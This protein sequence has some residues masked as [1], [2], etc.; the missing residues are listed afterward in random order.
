MVSAVLENNRHCFFPADFIS[1]GNLLLAV[2]TEAVSSRCLF[3]K[4][5]LNTKAFPTSL[6]EEVVSHPV[7][8]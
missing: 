1:S 3:D 8:A 5:F 7:R 2:T 6:I 4:S